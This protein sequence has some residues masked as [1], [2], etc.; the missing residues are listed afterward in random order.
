MA[1][2]E[3]EVYTSADSIDFD[4]LCLKDELS[5]SNNNN[6]NIFHAFSSQGFWTKLVEGESMKGG[7]AFQT[8]EQKRSAYERVKRQT[9]SRGI[10][11]KE[12]IDIFSFSFIIFPVSFHCF[13]LIFFLLHMILSIF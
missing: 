10:K 6:N 8:E 2:S 3:G 11:R 1:S 5:D 12:N 13:H 7:Q 4:C 9:L